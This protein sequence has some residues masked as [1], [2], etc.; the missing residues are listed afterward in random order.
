M[1]WLTLSSRLYPD[2]GFA[3]GL[4]RTFKLPGCVPRND[5]PRL[6]TGGILKGSKTFGEVWYKKVRGGQISG[7]QG[8]FFPLHAS[9]FLKGNLL[10]LWFLTPGVRF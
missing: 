3:L 4:R 5:I 8:G 2:A 10:F 7:S 6:T 9:S 1:W